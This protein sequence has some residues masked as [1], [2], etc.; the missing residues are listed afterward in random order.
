MENIKNTFDDYLSDPN[1]ENRNK[2]IETSIPIIENAV[3]KFQNGKVIEKN[4]LFQEGVLGVLEAIQK[5][6]SGEDFQ[7]KIYSYIKAHILKYSCN[8][9]S[10][11]INKYAKA[12]LSKINKFINEYVN[13]FQKEPSDEEISEHLKIKTQNLCTFKSLLIPSSELNENM[14]DEN[15]YL[16]NYLKL[17]GQ[18]YLVNLIKTKLSL[19]EQKIILSKYGIE[20]PK[21]TLDKIG[22]NLNPKLCKQRVDQIHKFALLKLKRII[23]DWQTSTF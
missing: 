7:K 23:K 11:T 16:N 1:N 8:Q 5:S 18:K 14:S 21:M 19:R 13:E 20:T 6:S 12:K 9:D 4:D 3:K 10:I 2:V 22:E 17:E 15:N